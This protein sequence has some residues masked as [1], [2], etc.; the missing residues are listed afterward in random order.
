MKD[1]T[2]PAKPTGLT[3]TIDSNGVVTLK[4]NMGKEEDLYGYLVYFANSKE[5]VFTPITKGFLVDTTFIDTI[6]LNSLTNKVYYTIVAF[7]LNRNASPYSDTLALARPDTIRPVPPVI[8]SYSVTDSSVTFY[9]S[10]SSSEDADSQF[11]YRKEISGNW[12]LLSKFDNKTDTYTDTTVKRLKRYLYS[13][14]TMDFSKLKSGK[15]FPLKVRVYDSGIRNLIY[16]FSAELSKDKKSV[17]LKWQQKSPN[18]SKVII[19]RNYNNNG[20][21]MYSSTA[22]S[23]NSYDDYDIQTGNY[24]YA[25]KVVLNN[26]TESPISKLIS[27]N[28]KR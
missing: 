21:Q 9:W 7:D 18:N 20:L 24:E 10:P 22:G 14:E 27:I 15:S 16:A 8:G 17:H 1:T 6:S 3:G 12:E 26:G 13:V 25:I 28:I 23:I 11:V 19:Y 2:P 4:W 5:H